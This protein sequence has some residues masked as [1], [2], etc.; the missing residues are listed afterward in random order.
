MPIDFRMNLVMEKMAK[1]KEAEYTPLMRVLFGL[2]TPTPLPAD[3]ENKETG[4]GRVEF[5]DT[6][7]NESQ[8]K[9]VLFALASR[10]VALIHGPPG[11][12]PLFQYLT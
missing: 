8:Q 4:V 10:E 3:L 9:A 1:M 12:R 7:L 5:N 11:V 6:T 2:G